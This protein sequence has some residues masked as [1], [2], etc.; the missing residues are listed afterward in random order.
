[1]KRL[2][3]LF[4]VIIT[5]L[6]NL[7]NLECADGFAQKKEDVGI[8]ERQTYVSGSERTIDKMTT[9]HTLLNIF[10]IY[11]DED[12]KSLKEILKINILDEPF[13]FGSPCDLY[14]L[15]VNGLTEDSGF[16][17]TNQH[18][19]ED[20]QTHIDFNSSDDDI[21]HISGD[22]IC[23]RP[24]HVQ[25]PHNQISN[26]LR[27]GLVQKTCGEIIFPEFEIDEYSSWAN[28]N[29][30]NTMVNA[31]LINA[32]GQ[33]R[34]QSFDESNIEKVMM[35]FYPFLQREVA[36]SKL[37]GSSLFNSLIPSTLISDIKVDIES[38]ARDVVSVAPKN[39]NNKLKET[40][41]KLGRKGVQ[42]ELDRRLE[43]KF[44][45]LL[46]VL[47]IDPSWH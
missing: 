21:K 9:Y 38:A 19:S 34:C 22:F 45:L 24:S 47:C 46:Y 43:V 4:I 32:C 14:N 10:S 18:N 35:L 23:Y 44:R 40:E 6:V 39:L 5:N 8:F 1:M 3:L 28:I 15:S 37:N 16:D 26:V 2:I 20:S 41:F 29:S 12:N 31:A 33:D 42:E 36:V 25:V 7:S 11:N 27:S 30:N 17:D 13:S